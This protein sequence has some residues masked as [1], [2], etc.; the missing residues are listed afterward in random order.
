MIKVAHVVTAYLSVITILD[1]KLRALAKYA[2]LDVTIISSPGETANY[3]SPAVRHIPTEM[4]RAIK[5]FADFKSIWRLYKVLKREQFDV[6]H[7]HTA[8]AGFITAIAAKMAKVPLICHTYHGLPFFDGQNKITYHLYRLLEKIVCKF[9]DYIFIQ[10]KKDLLQCVKLIG[11][12]SRVIFEGNGVDID[13]INQSAKNQLH[14]A[15]DDYPCKGTRI[16]LLS[17]LEPVKRVDDFF[18]VVEKLKQKGVKISC[19]VAGTGFLEKQLKN[20]LS[21]MALDDS[22]NMVGFTDHPHSLIAAS[23]I[24]VLCSEKEGIPR[25]ILEAMALEKPVVATDVLGTQEAVADGETG[26]LVPLG[27]IDAMAERIM[28]LIEDPK[29]RE[30]MG[31]YGLKR[32]SKEFNEIRTAESLHK[33]YVSHAHKNTL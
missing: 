1:S 9:R 29:L 28:L 18:K 10:N 20:R 16:A 3:R 17:R 27:N 2:D 6:V 13:F 7:S 21:K 15:L 22:I 11:D 5:P 23:D 31:S 32:V 8:K 33:F 26:F 12:E 30:K 14:R 25:A 4:T 19:V 24:V